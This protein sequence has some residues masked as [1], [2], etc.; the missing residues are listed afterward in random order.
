[1][2]ILASGQFEERRGSMAW[3]QSLAADLEMCSSL[4]AE[5]STTKKFW[6]FVATRQP[7]QL[8]K[9]GSYDLN[10][11]LQLILSRIYICENDYA[12]TSCEHLPHHVFPQTLSLP[13]TVLHLHT[14]STGASPWSSQRCPGSET[15]PFC[16]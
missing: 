12:T 15:H 6:V 13:T 8:G 10:T 14:M 5:E 1:M 7:R 9:R 4:Q 11:D 16:T 2:E 3:H